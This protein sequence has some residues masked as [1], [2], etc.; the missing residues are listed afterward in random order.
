MNAE[1]LGVNSE[2]KIRNVAI[3][4]FNKAVLCFVNGVYV[5]YIFKSSMKQLPVR[6]RAQT[7]GPE[8]TGSPKVT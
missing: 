3:V 4:V 7:K 1:V 6:S 5:F 8:V 2:G